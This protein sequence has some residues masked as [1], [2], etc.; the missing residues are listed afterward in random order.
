MASARYL[1]SCT[2][3]PRSLVATPPSATH[4]VG[5]PV[6]CD[7]FRAGTQRSSVNCVFG[8]VSGIWA[9]P[10][11]TLSC[12]CIINDP[13]GAVPLVTPAILSVISTG[14][15]TPV[16]APF[17]PVNGQLV[18]VF[19]GCIVL[20]ISGQPAPVPFAIPSQQYVVAE[21][22]SVYY[23]DGEIVGAFVPFGSPGAAV[24]AQQYIDPRNS[25]VYYFDG[26]IVGDFAL[27]PTGAIVPSLNFSVRE[28][29][30][31]YMFRGWPS[32][33]FYLAG[34]VPPVPVPSQSYTVAANSSVYWLGGQ[35][36]GDFT[37]L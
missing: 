30:G 25:S 5:R 31:L 8:P 6:S 18:Q 2:G 17:T 37:P 29:S 28:N 24:P 14:S 10:W 1:Q 26:E 32:G 4:D 7:V 16:P 36:D 9:N 23:F 19:P 15:A 34:Q 22:S 35:L 27:M 11:G 20:T 33:A 12:F 21:N 3:L 13:Y